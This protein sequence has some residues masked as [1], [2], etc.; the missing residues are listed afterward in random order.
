MDTVFRSMRLDVELADVSSGG[1]VRFENAK[2]ANVSLNHGKIVSTSWNDQDS[3]YGWLENSVD[4]EDFDVEYIPVP[5]AERSMFGEEF[6]IADQIM[7]DCLYNATD[8]EVLPGC[9][10][11]QAQG[12]SRQGR[13][14]HGSSNNRYEN[15]EEFL[16]TEDSLRRLQEHAGLKPMPPS[17]AGWPPF[18]MTPPANPVMRTSLTLPLPM[19]PGTAVPALVLTPEAAAAAHG[20]MHASRQP[21]G[22][23][24]ASRETFVLIV[25]AVLIAGTA[26]V[27][28]LWALLSLWH[29]SPKGQRKFGDE[30]ER[31]WPHRFPCWTVRNLADGQTVYIVFFCPCMSI[32]VF[33]Q[34][35]PG[36]I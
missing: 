21:P 6:L 15:I 27:A 26:A 20:A 29:R 16:L 2:L 35:F 10:L 3:E 23:G 24:E 5:V 36:C 31:P 1:I 19:P 12:M 32:N 33:Q 7:R 28:S 4:G 9:P 25:A 22:R 14:E 11:A 13:K 34:L 18:K 30:F 17:P 8:G